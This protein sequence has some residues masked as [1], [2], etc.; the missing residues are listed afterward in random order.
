MVD[1]GN[2]LFTLIPHFVL[3]GS[4][5]LTMKLTR[6]CLISLCCVS[7]ALAFGLVAN[8]AMDFL[9]PAPNSVVSE[10]P[11]QPVEPAAAPAGFELAAATSA[12]AEIMPVKVK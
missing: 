3:R 12:P 5:G 1:L 10:A 7:A 4:V 8:A 11:A 6:I 2:I 9:L